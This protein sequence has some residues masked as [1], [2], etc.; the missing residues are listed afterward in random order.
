MN[1]WLSFSVRK[2]LESLRKFLAEACL[3]LTTT[4]GAEVHSTQDHIFLLLVV[5]S[6]L[7]KPQ[8]LALFSSNTSTC[9][10]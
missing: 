5:A 3:L 9:A 7:M 6:H 1:E 4:F 10:C 8:Q 2:F